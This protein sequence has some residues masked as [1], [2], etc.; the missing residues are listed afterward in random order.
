MQVINVL[1]EFGNAITIT[2][3]ILG[4]RKSFIYGL[5]LALA[6]RFEKQI[7]KAIRKNKALQSLRFRIKKK[8]E[9]KMLTL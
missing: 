2:K 1:K 9:N 6:F 8:I 4:L 7:T 5:L 3:H